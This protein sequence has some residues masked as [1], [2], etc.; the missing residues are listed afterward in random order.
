MYLRGGPVELNTG[1]NFGN[2]G[3]DH[4]CICS[5]FHYVLTEPPY[6]I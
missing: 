5:F 4:L 1:D 2:A 6:T 3:N